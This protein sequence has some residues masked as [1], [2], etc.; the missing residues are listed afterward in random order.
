MIWDTKYLKHVIFVWSWNK[1]N[2][3]Q[4]CGIFDTASNV[5]WTKMLN[6][7]NSFV[8]PTYIDKQK[9]LW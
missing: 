9:L 8:W 7:R 3:D 1:Q 5:S 4:R 2:I 6:K